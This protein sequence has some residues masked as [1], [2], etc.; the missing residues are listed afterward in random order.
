M[1]REAVRLILGVA[2]LAASIGVVM[3]GNNP[4][5]SA[6]LKVGIQSVADI[7]AKGD[8]DG[9]S[10]KAADVAK[11]ASVEDAMHLFGL[12][13]KKG[14]GVGDAAGKFTPDGIEGKINNFSKKAPTK[15]D[16]TKD[17]DA[18]AMMAYRTAAIAEVVLKKAPEKDMGDKKVKDWNTYATNMRSGALEL[19]DAIKAQDAAKVKPA[20]AKVFSSCSSC[21][22]TFRD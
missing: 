10:K 21:H 13:A 3:A 8:A 17:A 1:K 20:A 22:G 4:A 11:G 16:L 2:F 19:A 5:D 14:Y 7:F 9:A 18:L 6:D 12:R 15:A